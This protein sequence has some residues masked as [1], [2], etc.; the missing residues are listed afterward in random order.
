[1]PLF[2]DTSHW[3]GVIRDIGLGPSLLG[4]VEQEKGR[5]LWT[6][7]ECC[8]QLEKKEGF[9]SFS[10]LLSLQST[11]DIH[12][13]P[14]I[15]MG[16]KANYGFYTPHCKEPGVERNPRGECLLGLGVFFGW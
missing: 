11:S 5:S 16:I 3:G 14:F 12:V 15:Q 4:W 7:L 9:C 6:F 13:F 2:Q 1:M 8:F 10:G